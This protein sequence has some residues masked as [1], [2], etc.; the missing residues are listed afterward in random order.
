MYEGVGR[1]REERT[2]RRTID[3][4]ETKTQVSSNLFQM[5]VNDS[6][7]GFVW[8]SHEKVFQ[9]TVFFC[10]WSF[11]DTVNTSVFGWLALR[12]GNKKMKKTIENPSICGTFK[13]P[14]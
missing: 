3:S 14:C 12:T 4:T 1:I 5:L 6:K 2:E 8:F 7:L 11:Q 10:M 13:A 9:N